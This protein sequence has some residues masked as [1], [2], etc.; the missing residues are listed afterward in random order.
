[1]S[2]EHHTKR[3]FIAIKLYPDDY[4]LD[5]LDQLQQDLKEEKIRWVKKEH[6]HLTLRFIGDCDI[7]R[8]NLITSMLEQKVENKSDFQLNVEGLGVFRSL[9]YPK[10]LWAGIRENR[11]LKILKEE[12][13]GGLNEI[14]FEFNSEKFSPHLTLGR[15]KRIKDRQKLRQELALFKNVFLFKQTVES[16]I[17][18]ESILSDDGPEYL[19]LHESFFFKRHD[20]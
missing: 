3:I 16:V 4:F 17:L 10:V 2:L 1:M 12:I 11:N 6:L 8:I 20:L 18:Y 19:P 14:G 13:D 9:S 15:M 7:D 5:H